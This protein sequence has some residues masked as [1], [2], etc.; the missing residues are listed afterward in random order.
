[1]WEY[2]ARVSNVVDGDTAD[3]TV[4]VGFGVFARQRLRILGVNAP[5]M[6]GPS[7]AAGRAARAFV[8]AWLAAAP[9]CEWPFVVTTQKTDDFG[10]YLA[11]VR[12]ADTGESLA[13]ALLQAGQATPYRTQS[14]AH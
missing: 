13:D 7:A 8:A 9:V 1:M 5:E 4:D 12:R 14:H 6:H 3:A 2:R 10:R 11:D